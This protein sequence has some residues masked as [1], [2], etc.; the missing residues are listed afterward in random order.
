MTE[1]VDDGGTPGSWRE[2]RDFSGYK[3]EVM[4]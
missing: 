4:Q 3:I 2:Q 1:N